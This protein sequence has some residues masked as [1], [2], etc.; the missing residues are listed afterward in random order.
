MK[1][2]NILIEKFFI[3]WE[4]MPHAVYNCT[5]NDMYMTRFHLSICA[6]R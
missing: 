2:E 3:F 1:E 4:K 6:V 5:V